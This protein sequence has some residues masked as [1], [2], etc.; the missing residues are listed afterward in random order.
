MSETI[1]APA[2]ETNILTGIDFGSDQQPG[3]MEA[4]QAETKQV[5]TPHHEP[6][7]PGT[8]A[9]N[10]GTQTERKTEEPAWF[11]RR[12][13]AITAKR[14]EAEERAAQ[15]EQELA[16]YR[17]ALAAARGEEE[18]RQPEMTPEQIRAEER[19][20]IEAQ[21][22]QQ[23][24]LEDFSAV[25]VKVAESLAGTH[26]WDAVK[27]LT[28]RLAETAGLDFN[29]PGHQQIIRDISELPNPGEVYYALAN[30]PD[31]ASAL[32]DA[33]ERR[34]YAML[35]KFA[36][37]LTKAEMSAKQAEAPAPR[38]SP[39]ISRTPAPVAAATG[40][41]RAVTGGRSLYDNGLSA[42]DFATM[43]NKR[44]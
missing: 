10:E 22:A 42:E 19:S 34:Q 18:P 35:Q 9:E 38:P 32:F 27:P 4:P 43:F 12:I 31:A 20:R 11:S 39:Q 15:A 29:N 37:G 40:S 16:E 36:D 14:R 33:P 1:Q 5:E 28:E 23:R 44:S 26:G 8:P 2:E 21:T 41:A 13:G 25:T 3:Q 6:G 7:T 24:Q 30:D 17:R